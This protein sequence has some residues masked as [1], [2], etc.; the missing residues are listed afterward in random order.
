MKPDEISAKSIIYKYK[1]LIDELY[2]LKE[3]L[4]KS[5]FHY[6]KKGKKSLVEYELEVISKIDN[7]IQAVKASYKEFRELSNMIHPSIE[8][9]S[10]IKH[11]PYEPERKDPLRLSSKRGTK[12]YGKFTCSE[13]HIA[14][15]EIWEYAESNHG[16]VR[17]CPICKNKYYDKSFPLEPSEKEGLLGP[18]VKSGGAWESNRRKH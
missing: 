18:L 13:C 10:K 4:K 1:D 3:C 6:L 11:V 9:D 2:K 8:D 15:S 7:H 14:S 5:K 17:L 12:R 16:F